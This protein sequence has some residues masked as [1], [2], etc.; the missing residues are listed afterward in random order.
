MSGYKAQWSGPGAA[1][2][3]SHG[4]RWGAS[5][6][7]RC[8]RHTRLC[9]VHWWHTCSSEE[10][11]VRQGSIIWFSIYQITYHSYVFFILHIFDST[12]ILKANFWFSLAFITWVFFFFSGF[13]KNPV[14]ATQ[15]ML[16]GLL[17]YCVLNYCFWLLR[18]PLTVNVCPVSLS[19]VFFLSF[20]WGST[21]PFTYQCWG[22]PHRLA[23]CTGV[24][25]L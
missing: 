21:C 24:F 5:H 2:C 14:N 12:I 6:S 3:R 20:F 19:D 15:D 17:N 9:Q 8:W 7:R 10:N 16:N 1:T 18:G 4:R 25:C 22:L 23:K 13:N 11:W